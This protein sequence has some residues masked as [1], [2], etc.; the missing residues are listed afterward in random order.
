MIAV[1][2]GLEAVR[3]VRS[4]TRFDIA[5]LDCQMPKMDGYEATANIRELPGGREL[6][7]IAL[8]ANAMKGD[9][10]RCLAAGMNDHLGKPVLSR[11]VESVLHRWLSPGIKRS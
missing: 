5:F 7:I 9:R 10:D 8:T 1:E 4:G 6:P 2:N 11:D 3:A